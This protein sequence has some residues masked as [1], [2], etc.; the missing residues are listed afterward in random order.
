VNDYV[1]WVAGRVAHYNLVLAQ[2]PTR[3]SKAPRRLLS[4]YI[5][6][7]ACAPSARII[8]NHRAVGAGLRLS[9]FS[10]DAG[11]GGGLDL[12]AKT[13]V[14]T[15]CQQFLPPSG[16]VAD[17]I[18]LWV[19]FLLRASLGLSPSTPWVEATSFPT[20][21][22]IMIVFVLR[23]FLACSKTHRCRRVGTLHLPWWGIHANE[24][25]QPVS[26]SRGLRALEHLRFAPR[27]R[28][29]GP[30]IGRHV[31]AATGRARRVADFREYS[32]ART[33]RRLA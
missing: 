9:I 10:A 25:R 2:W 31:S 32:A 5:L 29:E 15:T 4:K 20:L 12:A 3:C 27:Q 33:F 21:F 19:L 7:L 17:G 13:R 22:A 16:L 24:H 8:S 26:R 1:S 11:G 6:T 30:F 28:L 23:E 14:V 18:G